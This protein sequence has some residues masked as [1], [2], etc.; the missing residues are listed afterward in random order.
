M[1]GACLMV[2]GCTRAPESK[3]SALPSKSDGDVCRIEQNTRPLPVEVRETSGLARGIQNGDVLWTH[4][5]SGS[6]PEIFALG[7]DGS[8]KTRVSIKG[9][10]ETDWEDMAA[11]RCG[12]GAC[13]YIADTGDNYGERT[14]ITVYE[15]NEPTLSTSEQPVLRT[16]HARYPDGPQDAEALFRLPSGELYIVTKGRQK[17]IKLY[18]L[19]PSGDTT[20]A[21]MELVREIA[22]KPA[23]PTEWVTAATASPDGKWVAIRSYSTLYLYRTDDLMQGNLAPRSFALAPLGEKQGEAI[24]LGDDGTVWLSSEAE[25]MKDVPTFAKLSCT[26]Q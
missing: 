2:S 26:L 17:D 8:V 19:N 10:R 12:S 16:M 6:E 25:D 20:T 3:A 4:N 5:D 15:I 9:A 7:L 14:R 18:R 23:S 13:L 22:P 21:V 11:G 1:I 24:A